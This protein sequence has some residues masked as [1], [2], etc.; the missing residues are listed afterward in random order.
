MRTTVCE[1]ELSPILVS[2]IMHYFF[3]FLEFWSLYLYHEDN[4]TPHFTGKTK[5]LQ[6]QF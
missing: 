2:N 4:P 3:L 1:A 5:L 6:T